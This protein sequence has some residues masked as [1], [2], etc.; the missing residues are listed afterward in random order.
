MR[1]LTEADLKD[2]EYYS[3]LF[4][5]VE[6][7]CLIMGFELEDFLTA[8]SDPEHSISRTFYKGSLLS[9]VALREKVLK[10]AKQGSSPA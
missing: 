8:L 2:L 9:E 4:L 7:I 3:G 5:P 10:L 6:K 1:E